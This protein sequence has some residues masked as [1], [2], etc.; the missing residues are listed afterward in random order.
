VCTKIYKRAG[1]VCPGKL[2]G[3]AEFWHSKMRHTL[4]T[5][6]CDLHLNAVSSSTHV[7]RERGELYELKTHLKVPPFPSRDGVLAELRCELELV[8]GIRGAKARELRSRGCNRLEHLLANPQYSGTSARVLAF[9]DDPSP[10]N[11]LNLLFERFGASDPR[12]LMSL[13][14]FPEKLTFVDIETLGLFSSPVFLIGFARREGSDLILSQL[15]ARSLEAEAELLEKFLTL[16]DKDALFV[17]YNG[18]RFDVP[19]LN[20][21]FSYY[22]LER[23][24]DNPHVDLYPL[25]RRIKL[26]SSKLVALERELLGKARPWDL[27][28]SLVPAQYERYL[29]TGDIAP[30]SE[31]ALHNAEDIHSTYLL[32]VEMYR[33]LL[34]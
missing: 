2:S 24:L 15:I 3:F 26:E 11:V 13:F 20:Q 4:A 25:A 5:D 30:L 14:L 22:G 12:V 29:E 33:R 28:G 17:S 16:T 8:S 10:L 9:L 27:P 7:F 6:E 31:I 32:S 23:R 18:K 21:R 19:F 34:L 1:E